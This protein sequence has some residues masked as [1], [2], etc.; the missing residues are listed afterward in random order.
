[1]EKK[2]QVK[3]KYR[4]NPLSTIPGG[5][6]VTVYYSNNYS[7]VYD[8]VKYPDM[9]VKKVYDNAAKKKISVVNVT[10]SY[11]SGN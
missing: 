11:E 5:A 1:M 6:T 10:V 7:K 4:T 9:F 3:D 2:I 8:K